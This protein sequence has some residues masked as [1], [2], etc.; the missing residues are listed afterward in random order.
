M[1]EKMGS[2]D[3]VPTDILSDG[4]DSPSEDDPKNPLRYN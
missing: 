1:K 2:E 4:E 3:G